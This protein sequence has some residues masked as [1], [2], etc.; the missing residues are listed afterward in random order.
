MEYIGKLIKCKKFNLL[1]N[2]IY[3]LH[4][5]LDNLPKENMTWI[6]LYEIKEKIVINMV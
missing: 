4:N 6:S 1:E 3:D 5:T 2:K